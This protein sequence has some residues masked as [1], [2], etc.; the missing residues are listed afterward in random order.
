MTQSKDYVIKRLRAENK[1]LREQLKA[2]TDKETEVN[3]FDRE[4]VYHNCTV[5]IWSNSKTGACS[6]GWIQEGDTDVH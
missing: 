4:E 6:I 2:I 5:Q 3:V 1:K